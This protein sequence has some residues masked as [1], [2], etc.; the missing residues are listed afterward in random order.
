MNVYD[1][2]K[3]I[4]DGDSS[5][6]FY[7]F[8]LLKKPYIVVLIPSILWGFI[9]YKLRFKE[10]EYFK[11]KYF[12]FVKCFSNIDELV[13]QFWNK[14]EGKIKDWYLKQRKSNDVII[15]A[16]PNFLIEEIVKRLGVDSLIASMVDSENGLFLSKN[17]YGKEKVKRYKK[18][19]KNIVIENFYSDS[20][21]DL[22]M[23]ELSNNAFLV[24]GDSI[25][26]ILIQE[27]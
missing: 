19:F 2:D 22:P 27:K 26:K 18:K 24:K 16:S 25:K 11:E 13:I 6:D 20:M 17:C 14:N 15:T 4:Y 10:K 5:V 1:F 3:T 12:S 8:C 7:L 21:S 9:L 23:M